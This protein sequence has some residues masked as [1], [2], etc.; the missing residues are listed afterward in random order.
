MQAL[1]AN[2]ASTQEQFAQWQRLHQQY[3]QIY[4]GPVENG[5]GN[6]SDWCVTAH[7]R[8]MSESENMNNRQDWCGNARSNDNMKDEQVLTA[9][10]V[11]KEHPFDIQEDKVPE[12]AAAIR[13]C[14]IWPRH[15]SLAVF[16]S[17]AK[18]RD[19]SR[20]FNVLSQDT[21]LGGVTKR[22]KLDDI[23]MSWTILTSP[24]SSITTRGSDTRR[25]SVLVGKYHRPD[26]KETP[27]DTIPGRSERLESGSFFHCGDRATRT[28]PRRHWG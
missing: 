1:A 10:H 19:R 15:R 12:L 8:T 13:E 11:F 18:T 27:N 7:S 21:L 4:W 20:E 26:A 24:T 6:G 14:G 9:S 5:Y 3:E 28:R 25:S 23:S 17:L 16:W 2:P 22:V